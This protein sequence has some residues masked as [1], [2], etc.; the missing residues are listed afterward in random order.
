MAC[1]QVCAIWEHVDD[2]SRLRH[3]QILTRNALHRE[4]RAVDTLDLSREPAVLLLEVVNLTAKR[5]NASPGATQLCNSFLTEDERDEK[6]DAEHPGE[7]E[8]CLERYLGR[9]LR[10]VR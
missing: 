8:H 6:D 9:F 5:L 7:K 4:G 1:Q 10:V 3:P 2:L